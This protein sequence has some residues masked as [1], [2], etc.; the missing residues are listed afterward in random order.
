LGCETGW[1]NSRAAHYNDGCLFFAAPENP[2]MTTQTV[3][4]HDVEVIPYKAQIRAEVRCGDLRQLQEAAFKALY[5]ALETMPKALLARIAGRTIKADLRFTSGGQL[6]PGY[7]GKEDI[8][9]APGPSHPII[10][11][12]EESGH[13]ALYNE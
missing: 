5:R 11:R 12:H 10:R 1:V 3:T 8:R 4:R 13:H 2:A 9:D 7:T 6:R